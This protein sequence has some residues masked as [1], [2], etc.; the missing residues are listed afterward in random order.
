MMRMSKAT[1]VVFVSLIFLVTSASGQEIGV[2]DTSIKVGYLTVLTGPAAGIGR[3]IGQGAEIAFKEVNDAGG[4][5]GR[6]IEMILED[7]AYNPKQ[8]VAGIKKLTNRD[9]IFGIAG[10]IGAAPGLAAVPLAQA[11]KIPTF[12]SGGLKTWFDPPKRYVFVVGM[13]YR[14]ELISLTEYAM[15]NLA[16]SKKK[17]ALLFQDDSKEACM[18]ASKAI[19]EHYGIDVVTHQSFKRRTP[20]PSPQILALKKAGAEVV[21]VLTNARDMALI[22][23]KSMELNYKPTYMGITPTIDPSIFKALPPGDIGFYAAAS[24]APLSMEI[25]GIKH[26]NE[27]GNKYYPKFNLATY[28]L[29]GYVPGRIFVNALK[30]AGRDL[31]REKFIDALEKTKDLDLQGLA[32]PVTYNANRRYSAS[33]V[34]VV[35]MDTAEKTFKLVRDAEEVDYNPFKK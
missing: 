12:L 29:L 2:T 31:T 5:H 32:P 9:K 16:A 27:L 13:P 22:L 21:L 23:K 18:G 15:K 6:K 26:L 28:H 24:L 25:P 10:C 7:H 14:L 11:G 4:V 3:L 1:M 19:S 35:K 20:D 30:V 8:T 33:S 17:F 34:M